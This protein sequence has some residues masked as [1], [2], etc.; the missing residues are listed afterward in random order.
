MSRN[1]V[2]Q[3][4]G[5][6]VLGSA[7]AVA[8]QAGEVKAPSSVNE[9]APDKT[10]KEAKGQAGTPTIPS[11]SPSSVS[12]SAPQKTGKEPVAAA[13]G[14]DSKAMANPKTPSSVSESAPDK[15]AK[16]SGKKKDEKN[17]PY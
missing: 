17:K 3:I 15:A 16:G 10:G 2:L 13:P 4:V 7:L 12:E 5:A 6:A 8:T 1:S 11:K 14:A 9:S